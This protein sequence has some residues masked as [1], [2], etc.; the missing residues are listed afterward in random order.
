MFFNRENEKRMTFQ[1]LLL[2]ILWGMAIFTFMVQMCNLPQPGDFTQ[3]LNEELNPS[4]PYTHYPLEYNP[5]NDRMT[6]LESCIIWMG[7]FY[8]MLRIFNIMR[9]IIEDEEEGKWFYFW[10]NLEK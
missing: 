2:L 10:N 3:Q 6:L 9:I 7:F 4:D 1:M 8:G 5:Y